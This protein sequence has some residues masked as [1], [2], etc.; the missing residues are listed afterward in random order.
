M[1]KFIF[2]ALLLCN[3]CFWVTSPCEERYVLV[4]ESNNIVHMADFS[5]DSVIELY[6]C[7]GKRTAVYPMDSLQ[8]IRENEESNITWRAY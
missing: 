6:D 3:G 2:L 8:V 4:T 7:Y 5:I 1:K